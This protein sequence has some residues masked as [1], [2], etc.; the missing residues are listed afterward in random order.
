MD[1]AAERAINR[2]ENLAWIHQAGDLTCAIRDLEDGGVSCGIVLELGE[3]QFLVTAGH[4][5]CR[6]H[7]LAF[8]GPDGETPIAEVRR[9]S[10]YDGKVDVGFVEVDE[11]SAPAFVGFAREDTLLTSLPRGESLWI[12][13]RGCPAQ[14]YKPQGPDRVES[15]DFTV[16][17]K[18]VPQDEWPDSWITESFGAIRLST[19]RDLLVTYPEM[20]GELDWV[21]KRGNP[22]RPCDLRVPHPNGFSGAGMWLL[23]F[24]RHRGSEVQFPDLKLVGIQGGFRKRLGCLRGTRIRCLLNLIAED[25][26]ALGDAVEQVEKQSR[27]FQRRQRRLAGGGQQR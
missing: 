23:C 16:P 6:G 13:V 5:L 10:R 9:C 25:Y 15:T 19:S 24:S 14:Y 7:A 1:D 3:R 11:D 18:L 17:G 27:N 4:V 2:W 22:P 26:S 21:D 8:I 20:G 12:G